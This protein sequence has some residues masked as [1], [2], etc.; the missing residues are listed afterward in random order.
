MPL[1]FAAVAPHGFPLI[2]D[3]SDDAGG[4]LTT[5]AAM[6]ELG[7]R[8]VAAGVEA[9]VI[10][11]PH[12]VRIDGSI[13]LADTARTAGSL[14][15]QGRAVELSVPIDG[16][17]TNGVVA[18]ARARGIPIAMVGYGGHR[19]DTSVLPLDWGILTP[20]WFLG[21]GRNMPGHGNVLSEPPANI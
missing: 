7:R 8:A 20:L 15:W 1:E 21:H 19:R 17:L 11:G 18:T 16:P 2:P 10:A 4:A 5:R 6:E 3:L 9:L 13:S 14:T 12:G